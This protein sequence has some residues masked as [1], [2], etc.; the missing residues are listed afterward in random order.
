MINIHRVTYALVALVLA[1]VGFSISTRGN[2]QDPATAADSQESAATALQIHEARKRTFPIADYD[3]PEPSDPSKRAARREKQKRYD[4]FSLVAK[5]PHPD[6]AETNFIGEP[7]VDIPALPVEKSDVIVVGDVIAGEAHLSADKQNVFS[8]FTIRVRQ[9][10]KTTALAVSA[11]DE[12]II[13]ERVGGFVRYPNGQTVL[14]RG[15]GVGMPR[16]GGECLLFLNLIP[17]SDAYTI[18]SGYELGRKGVESFDYAG[19]LEAFRGFDVP[20]FLSTFEALLT[21]TSAP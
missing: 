1:T 3:E 8:E 5:D 11:A 4:K 2:G 14:Y 12:L 10:Y 19:R 21:K 9:V 18:L 20:T 15:A 6:T 13:V 16:V 7:H 17:R